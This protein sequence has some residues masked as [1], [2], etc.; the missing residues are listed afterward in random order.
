MASATVPETP[1]RGA[2]LS[3]ADEMTS[4]IR[5]IVALFD[6]I[7]IGGLINAA[8]ATGPALGEQGLDQARRLQRLIDAMQSIPSGGAQ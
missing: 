1:A 7:A 5:R 6:V 3:E 2:T 4:L 8:D